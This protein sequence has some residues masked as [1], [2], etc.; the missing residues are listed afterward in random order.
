ML[1]PDKSQVHQA[2]TQLLWQN[3]LVGGFLSTNNVNSFK[4]KRLLIF[5]WKIRGGFSIRRVG[6]EYYLLRFELNHKLVRVFIQESR[7]VM[8]DTFMLRLLDDGQDIYE[9][10]LTNME[11]NLTISELT[12]EQAE[13]PSNIMGYVE[14]RISCSF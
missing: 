2:A 13:L 14:T 3:C 7:A 6:F 4:L 5:L 11:I 9:I 12:R 8:G 10:I 1:F